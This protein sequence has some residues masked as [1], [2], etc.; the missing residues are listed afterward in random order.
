[1]CK[2]GKE[3]TGSN[4]SNVN[5][6]I[7]EFIDKETNHIFVLT[8]K[9]MLQSFLDHAR[10]WK[11]DTYIWITNWLLRDTMVCEMRPCGKYSFK[12]KTLPKNFELGFHSGNNCAWLSE[13]SQ[14]SQNNI[15]I[16]KWSFPIFLVIAAAKWHFC[17][18]R[19]FYC[20][21]SFVIKWKKN[22]LKHRYTETLTHYV[23]VF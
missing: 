14:I 21:N 20:L 10:Y 8:K 23:F 5:K 3:N 12:F 9:N 16:L 1:M 6:K 17:N 4:L 15:F 2:C 7:I 22:V 18:L 13:T 19:E 11:L